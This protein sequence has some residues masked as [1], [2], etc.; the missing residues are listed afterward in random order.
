MT[1]NIN[2]FDPGHVAKNI[3]TDASA[4]PNGTEDACSHSSFADHLNAARSEQVGETPSTDEAHDRLA[5]T[6][7]AAGP[8]ATREQQIRAV[9]ATEIRTALGPAAPD[10]LLDQVCKTVMEQEPLSALFDRLASRL[11]V[12]EDH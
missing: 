11:G 8:N 5:H 4:R 10:Q 12:A 1:P 2:R 7:A 6:I 3:E 9:V